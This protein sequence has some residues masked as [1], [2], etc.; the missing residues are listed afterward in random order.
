M[1]EGPIIIIISIIISNERVLF[2]DYERFFWF[3]IFVC[4]DAKIWV[5]VGHV[6]GVWGVTEMGQIKK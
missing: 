2:F 5:D 4:A 6:T 3:E 1:E